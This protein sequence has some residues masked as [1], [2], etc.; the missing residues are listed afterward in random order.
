M[1]N[2]TF[3]KKDLIRVLKKKTGFSHNFLEKIVKDLIN[4]IILNLKNGKLNLK[5]LG[6]FKLIN[7]KERI[8]RNPKTKKEHVIKSRKSITFIP[9]LNL[10]R[11]FIEN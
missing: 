3:A 8:G 11:Y 6:S 5:N 9:S 4:I 7:K 1:L 10:K 2:R